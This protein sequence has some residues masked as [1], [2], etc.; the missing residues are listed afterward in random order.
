MCFAHYETHCCQH[1]LLPLFTSP[2]PSSYESCFSSVCYGRGIVGN[3]VQRGVQRYETNR[4]DSSCVDC[5]PAYHNDVTRAT[6][7]SATVPAAA[8]PLGAAQMGEAANSRL[9]D[10]GDGADEVPK[11][12]SERLREMVE[13]AVRRVTESSKGKEGE[14]RKKVRGCVLF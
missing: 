9:W 4:Y 2:R 8:M 10:S 3:C 1:C 14:G 6:R 11:R 7:P 13:M 12:R 5:N